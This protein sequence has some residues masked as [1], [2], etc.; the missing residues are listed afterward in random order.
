LNQHLP[1]RISAARAALE[2][3][4]ESVYKLHAQSICT[5]TRKVVE[6]I[7]ELELLADVI[8][9]HR[10]AINTQG[11]L[12]KLSDIKPED[13]TFLDEMMTKYS[14]YEHAQS[15]EAPVELPLP[16]DLAGDVAKLKKWR[17]ELEARRK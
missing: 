10:R 5:E 7:I 15:A 11:K 13:C 16:D 4:G 2:K 1:A 6:R 17:D 12:N 14:R 8:Q 3:E 9:R